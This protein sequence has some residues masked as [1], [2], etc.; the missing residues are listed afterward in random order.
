MRA[1]DAAHDEL[2]ALARPVDVDEIDAHA[3]AA[4]GP[5]HRA[6]C[7]RGAAASS[8]HLAEVVGVHPDLQHAPAPL[9]AQVDL[10][11]IRVLDDAPDEVLERL[12]EHQLSAG[13]SSA[14]SA[15]GASSAGASAAGAS[16]S[17]AGGSAVVSAGASAAGGSAGADS[18]AGVSGAAAAFFAALFFGVVA[19][20][21]SSSD[22]LAAA[23]KMALRSG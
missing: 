21:L 13:V 17:A 4:K 15:A 9:C 14:A 3:T 11:L 19:G 12:F 2:H 18:A 16:A 7:A 22:S 8:D 5:H 20:A 6:Q 10:D 1:G 23:S